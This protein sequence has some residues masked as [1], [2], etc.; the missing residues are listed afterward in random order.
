MKEYSLKFTLLARYAPTMVANNTSRMMKFVFGVTNIMVKE[1]KTSML[2][3]KMDL[4]SLV[5]HAQ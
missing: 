2:I 1:C 4:S 3:K 5:A